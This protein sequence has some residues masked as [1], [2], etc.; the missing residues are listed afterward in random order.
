MHN[1]EAASASEASGLCGGGCVWFAEVRATA[2][3][4]YE[5][6]SVA[7]RVEK[8]A[9][10]SAKIT[11]LFSETETAKQNQKNSFPFLFPLH[12]GGVGGGD[13]RKMQGN[14]LVFAHA[15]PGACPR[16]IG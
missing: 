10:K 8:R 15:L 13:A 14:F 9:N 5:S 12:G 6:T 7:V 3:R 1:A 2:K 16:R 11:V 4:G